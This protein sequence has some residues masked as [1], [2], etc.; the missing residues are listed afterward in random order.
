MPI[1]FHKWKDRWREVRLQ[2][3]KAS[4]RELWVW[5]WIERRYYRSRKAEAEPLKLFL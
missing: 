4:R 1:G 2:G 3:F 5:L